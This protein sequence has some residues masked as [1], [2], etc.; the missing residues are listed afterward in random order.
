MGKNWQCCHLPC[1]RVC[2]KYQSSYALLIPQE[3]VC[4]SHIISVPH[5]LT[6]KNVSTGIRTNLGLF[7]NISHLI[8]LS[9]CCY[10]WYSNCCYAVLKVNWIYSASLISGFTLLYLFYTNTD[11]F[12]AQQRIFSL[13]YTCT[14]IL[15]GGLFFSI[16]K[17]DVQ[18]CSS[19]L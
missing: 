3:N 4:Q 16:F 9:Y 15:I 13:F 19:L 11:L 5:A 2:H 14:Y 18:Y 12:N 10:V 8:H 1:R 6:P 7:R 17:I